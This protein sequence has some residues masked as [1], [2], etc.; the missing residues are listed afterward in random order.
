MFVEIGWLNDRV[1]D[2]LGVIMQPIERHG[3]GFMVSDVGC[4]HFGGGDTRP[5]CRSI[6]VTSLKSLYD[7]TIVRKFNSISNYH[8]SLLKLSNFF[9][10]HTNS[11][12][13]PP[14]VLFYYLPK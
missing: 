3:F 2:Q 11:Y 1:W 12:A 13:V 10:S 6:L 8:M 14:R 9:T 4:G 5:R 7:A